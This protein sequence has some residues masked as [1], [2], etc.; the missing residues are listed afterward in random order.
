MNEIHRYNNV[1]KLAS[2]LAGQSLPRFAYRS[3]LLHECGTSIVNYGTCLV[4][5]GKYV[6]SN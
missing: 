1:E 3:A 6:A 2:D 5:T 4:R